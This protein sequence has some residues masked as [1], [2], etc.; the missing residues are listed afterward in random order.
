MRSFYTSKLIILI[1]LLSGYSLNLLAQT[2]TFNW[3]GTTFGTGSV[4][5]YTVGAGV[6]QLGIDIK[7]GCGGGGYVS[8]GAP[9]PVVLGGRV[10]CSVNVT[11]GT[12]LYVFV[13]GAG[14]TDGSG[15]Y[16]PIG[17][18]P[19]GANGQ[20]FSAAGGGAS[21]VSLSNA[22]IGTSP[23]SV[24]V[25]GAGGG[26]GGDWGTTGGAGGGLTGSTGGTYAGTYV[27]GGGGTQTGPGTGGNANGSQGIGGLCGGSAGGGASGWWGGNGGSSS[28]AGGGG[29]SSYAN[30]TYLI[31]S[32]VHTGGYSGANGNGQVVITVLCSSPGSIVGA[33]PVCPGSTITLTNPTGAGG[34]WV[35]SNP[36]IASIN[37]STGVLTGVAA[38]TVT[39]TYQEPNPCGG[40]SAT[41][42]VTVLPLPGAITGTTSACIGNTTTLSDGG[43]G[44]WVSSNP[45]VATVSS[46]GVVTGIT[47]GTTT[48]SYTLTSGCAPATTTATIYPTPS[49]IS[50][51]LSTCASG[52]TSTLTDALTGGSWTSSSTA[53]ATIGAGSGVVTG[54]VAGT[55]N[56]TY[57]SA[58]GCITSSVFT[59]NPL[60]LGIAGTANACVGSSSTLSDPTTG[61]TWTSSNTSQAT[62]G[63]GSGVVTGISSGNPT[64]TYTLAGTGCRTTIGFVVNPL[65]GVITGASAVCT[66]ST[67]S[68]SDAGGGT[69]TSSNLLSATVNTFSGLVSGV[70]PGTSTITY[71]LSTGCSVSTSI[72]VNPLPTAY[73]VTGGGNYCAMGSGVHIGLSYAN[74]GVNYTL[75]NGGTAVSLPTPGSNS[76]MDFGLMTS[77]GT[78]TVTGTNSVTGCSISMTGL[79]SVSVNPLPLVHNITGGGGYCVG[80]SGSPLGIDGTDAGVHY[81][82]YNSG[83]PVG[84]V[85][86]GTGSPMSFGSYTATGTYTVMAID[87]VTTCSQL[88]GSTAVISVVATPTT[89]AV[90]GGGSYCA[91]GTGVHINLSGSDAGTTYQLIRGGVSFGPGLTSIGGGPLDFGL[92]TTPGTYT[93]SASSLSGCTGNMP[94]SVTVVINP[95][96]SVNNVTGGGGYC[97][98]GTGRHI[99]LDF[100]TP[101]ISYSLI[102][103]GGTVTTVGGSGS[104]LDFGAQMVPGTYTVVAV[105]S[106]TLCNS[107]M[108]GSAVII[109]NPLPTTYNVMGGGSYCSGDPGRDI[110]TDGSEGGVNYQLY[111]GITATGL[112]IGGSILGTGVDFGFFTISGT[113]TV[114]ATNTVT[115]CSSNM[116]GSALITVN[117][118]PGL[119][120]VTGGGNYCAG[121]PGVAVG[122]NGSSTGISYQLK[123][124]GSIINTVSGTGGTVDFGYQ[125]TP[126][127][128]TVVAM[129]S[130]TGCMKNMLGSAVVVVNPVPLVDTVTG[131]GSY[132]A[133][134]TGYHIGLNAST[135]G[136]SYR[137]YNGSTP[138][139]SAVTGSGAVVDFGIRTAA[140]TYTVIATNPMT[141]CWSNMSGSALININSLP[142]T[143]VLSGSGNYCAGG[144]GKD[145]VLS[146]SDLNVTY[147]IYR[148]GV[149]VGSVMAGTGTGSLDFGYDTMG[150]YTAKGTDAF[151]GCSSNM[152]GTVVINTVTPVA[153]TVTG[154]GSYCLGG[155]GV[156]ITQS[157][158]ST[159]VN[160]QLYNGA[161]LIG[162][163]VSGT[164][165][166]LNFGLQ[167]GAGTY[168]VQAM[169]TTL[170]C[171]GDMSGSALIT[172]NSLPV[173]ENVT[174]G[175]AYCAGTGGM[176][177]GLN[178]SVTGVHYQLYHAGAA[179]G[180][181][182]SGVTGSAVDFGFE[183]GAGSYTVTGTDIA[184]GCT[185]LMNDSAVITIKP[186]PVP[187]G[188]TIDNYGNYCASDSGVHIG[189]LNSDAGVNYQLFRGSTPIGSVVSGTGLPLNLGMQSVAGG[190][191][192]VANNPVSGCSTN[193]PGS[194]TVNIVPLPGEHN[195]T[196]GGGFCPGGT[197]IAVGLDG[198]EVGITYQLYKDGISLG[199]GAQI[200]GTG[201]ALNYGLQTGTGIYTV[202]A[203]NVIVTTPSCQNTMFG[204]ADVHYYAILT[205]VVTIQA[206]P[207]SGVG[208]GQVDSMKVFV[209]NGGANPTFQWYVNGHAI[210]GAT[211][212]TFSGYGFFNK[213]SVSCSVTASGP[214][215][216]NTTSKSVVLHLI[217]VGVR[218]VTTAS[219]EVVLSPNPN[220]GVFSLKGNL[221]TATDETVILEVTNMLGQVVYT[222]QA[223][224][225]GGNIDEQLSL[226]SLANGMYIL[227]TVSG[228]QHTVFHFVIEQ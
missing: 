105:N 191:T 181:P 93:V 16:T 85:V 80:T 220:S 53:T 74:S 69:W 47:A 81:Q 149:P 165:A 152:I 117:P 104:G 36:S 201:T 193:M 203:S 122:L 64:I 160:Y 24:L 208:V 51:T 127:I 9:G 58:N 57:T 167:T 169:D 10:Q 121:G 89:Y 82:L 150:V 196:G 86:T 120:T 38:G 4:Q 48:I 95:S 183:T 124:G 227:N 159:G 46:S 75:Y 143:Y 125:L 45:A 153:F 202:E 223:K 59:V 163:P 190:Y 67:T 21:F 161:T 200:F 173:A 98:G 205:P 207:G 218:P 49:A 166:S 12:T 1:A 142:G 179:M 199:T 114:K 151:T 186:T 189:L 213:D 32:A 44:T 34:T 195:V 138:S 13:A 8:S 83:S 128:Y 77:T 126:G 137:L 107:N 50:G 52:S 92:V 215:G 70:A 28:G 76:G 115:G 216:G 123:L 174:G 209:T 100:S 79:V 20:S 87:P 188:L 6:T 39:I 84:P 61:G 155:T 194:V 54:L 133:G 99:G 170:G 40:V 56:I 211:L 131:G 135:S 18:W 204:T 108:A 96:P 41:A 154:G 147:Q 139:G 71:T 221:G 210:A 176:P 42:S 184:T 73:T 7:G 212:A 119:H 157:G 162:L 145:I 22:L 222:G 55:T 97:A 148:S 26:G 101:G 228:T 134:G 177:V 164:G 27:G 19:G 136:I 180:V 206:Y 198:S 178:T 187:Y 192:V 68:L 214:C 185:N 112:P 225:A 111:R 140:G 141:G 31:G 91:G 90:T 25:V 37:S 88:M 132:C 109:V 15:G 144:M 224:S 65:P 171:V 217:G 5:T 172:I 35:S 106:T 29:G 23:S 2:T 182:L 102:Y 43:T 175:G 78:Y 168:T 60:P 156:A 17:G 113:Y 30:P 3:N 11:P 33:A 94:G 158:S 129:D 62:V 197:G 219:A 66:G 103:G 118:L 72:L 130:A 226:K 63:I 116:L 14:Q 110:N 146:G